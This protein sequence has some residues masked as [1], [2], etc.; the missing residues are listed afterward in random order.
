MVPETRINLL[1]LSLDDLA[2]LLASWGQPRFRATQI[3]RWIYHGLT[4]DVDE[5]VNLP[6][7]L[8]HRLTAETYVGRFQAADTVADDGGLTEKTALV[9]VDGHIIETVWMRYT[10]RNTICISSQIGCALGCLFCAT[11]Q[12][13]LVR[14]LSA[15]E[16]AAQVLHYAAKLRQNNAHVTNVVLMGMGEPMLNFDAVWKAILNLNDREGLAL[17]MRRFTVSTAGI[18]PGIER[19]A[20]EGA[21]VGLGVSLHAPTDALRDQ[22]VPLNRRYPL[23]RLLPACRLYVERTGRRVTFEY[24]LVNGVNDAEEHAVQT[25]N[26][27][28]GMLC[29]I[30]LIPVN[31]VPGCPYEPSPRDRVLRFQE[32]LVRHKMQT[33]VRLRRGADI[34]AGC[35]QLKARILA[36]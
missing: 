7:E 1:D 13:G 5:M 26:L 17:G 27:L 11:G 32:V 35:G 22:L 24:A 6:K 34:Q 16:I 20:L 36:H 30:N 23:A 19:M 33:T 15:G 9:T 29:H 3:W 25:A 28:R 31:P 10:S 18:V 14:D 21:E 12:Q 8:R 4:A 2:Q